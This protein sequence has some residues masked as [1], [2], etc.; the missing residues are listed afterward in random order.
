MASSDIKALE[1]GKLLKD[2]ERVLAC[3]FQ[4]RD[5]CLY[6][7]G[8]VG[9]AMKKNVGTIHIVKVQLFKGLQFLGFTEK[10]PDKIHIFISDVQSKMA[11]HDLKNP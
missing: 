10:K 6:L 9:A 8:I 7:S 5:G 4:Q 1:K 3:S 11:N 2:S